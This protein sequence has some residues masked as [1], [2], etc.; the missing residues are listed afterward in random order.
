M[1]GAFYF[2]TIDLLDQLVSQISSSEI[3]DSDEIHIDYVVR[4]AGDLGINLVLLRTTNF[5]SWGTPNE[6]KVYDYWAEYFAS[7]I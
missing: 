1:T 7:E 5:V 6:L 4:K 2:S 3:L